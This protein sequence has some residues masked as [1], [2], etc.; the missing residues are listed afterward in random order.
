MSEA[1]AE[2][3]HENAKKDALLKSG[4]F[5]CPAPPLTSSWS[6]KLEVAARM[7][8]GSSV[9]VGPLCLLCLHPLLSAVPVG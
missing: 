6:L 3:V 7:V 1:A 8:F 9:V 4:L 5:S 2:R